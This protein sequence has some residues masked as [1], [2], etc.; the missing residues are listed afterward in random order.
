MVVLAGCS[1]DP[2]APYFRSAAATPE[3]PAKVLTQ[4]VVATPS[5]GAQIPSGAIARPDAK[6]TPGVI[7]SSDVATVCHQPSHAKGIFSPRSRLV[8][9]ADQAA[10]F[11]AYRISAQQAKHYGL[12]FLIPLQ[13]GGANTRTNIWPMPLNRGLGFHQKE[14]LN[15]RVH[16]LVCHGEMRIDQAQHAFET[17]WVKLWSQYGA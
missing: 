2:S 6:L 5:A 14:I 13:L 4:R 11:S 15:I 9:A 17:D 8:S 3:S 10:V 12:D 16:I 7:A 1:A